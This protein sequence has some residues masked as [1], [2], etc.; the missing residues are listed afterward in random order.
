MCMSRWGAFLRKKLDPQD[1]LSIV[2][3][4]EVCGKQLYFALQAKEL[5]VVPPVCIVHHQMRRGSKHEFLAVLQKGD[6]ALSIGES[7]YRLDL[8]VDSI[9]KLSFIV[10]LVAFLREK[11]CT[12]GTPL[13]SHCSLWKASSWIGC[14]LDNL[15]SADIILPD[16]YYRSN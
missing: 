10:G 9:E 4:L 5:M 12:K 11:R 1:V 15:L 14:R 3:L 7:A 2:H 6:S 16:F 13:I 8:E